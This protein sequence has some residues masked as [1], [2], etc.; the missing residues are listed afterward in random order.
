MKKKILTVVGARPQ[1]IKAAI[2]SKKI[3]NL[4]LFN[5]II[6][7]TGQHY[8]ENMS[9][10]FF[11]KLKIKKPKYYLSI[12]NLTHNLMIS[13]MIKKIDEVYNIEKPDGLIVYGDTNST[14]SAAI[15]AKK[16]NIPIFHVEAGVRNYDEFMPEES[17]RY[18]VDRISNINFCVTDSNIKNLIFEG[19]KK[20]NIQ[21]KIIKSGDVMYDLFKD[22]TK[23][24]INKKKNKK[25]E[26]VVCTIHR[27]SNTDNY[28]NLKNI[29]DALNQISNSKKIVFVCHPRTKKKIIE[30]RLICNFEI[31]NPVDYQRMINYILGCEFVITD[32]G[33]IVREA[34]FAKKKSLLIL[35]SAFWPEIVKENYCINVSA[36]KSKILNAFNK[37]KKIKPKNN[38][39]IFGNGNA[40]NI[41]VRKIYQ[42]IK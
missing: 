10:I 31:L 30:K 42:Y 17:N 13:K 40:A 34:F 38:T 4:K 15:A 7:H 29:I 28:N 19:Y 18:L 24:M 11:K 16:R 6:I 1:F 21:S 3:L 9:R 12:K 41:I 27:E 20:K 5:E 26:Y 33:G 2:V 25:T 8:D 36:K 37:M 23:K 32:S 22:F 39:N 35:E 14:L